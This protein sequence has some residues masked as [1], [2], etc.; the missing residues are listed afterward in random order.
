MNRVRKNKITM[1]MYLSGDFSFE[2]DTA[3]KNCYRVNSPI[4]LIPYN[5]VLTK[6]QINVLVN[7]LFNSH[8]IRVTLEKVEE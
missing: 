7:T 8:K 1:D 3:Q 5:Y 4:K 2:L 6:K